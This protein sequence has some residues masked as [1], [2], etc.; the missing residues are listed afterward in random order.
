M[1]FLKITEMRTE[2]LKVRQ[3]QLQAE[4]KITPAI[5]RPLVRQNI[6]RVA[7]ELKRRSVK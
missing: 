7:Q 1:N 3:K 4:L 5:V 2:A 6:A